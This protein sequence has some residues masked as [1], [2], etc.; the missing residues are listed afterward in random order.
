MF[1]ETIKEVPKEKTTSLYSYGLGTTLTKVMDTWKKNQDLMETEFE[2]PCEK[3]PFKE[4]KIEMQMEEILENLDEQ[5]E[6]EEDF[7]SFYSGNFGK[8]EDDNQSTTHGC[9]GKG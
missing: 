3:C 1:V 7:E 6:E 5:E 9:H 8:D 4:Y 2:N